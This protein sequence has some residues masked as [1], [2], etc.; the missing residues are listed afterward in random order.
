MYVCMYVCMY[1]SINDTLYL[2]HVD[3]ENGALLSCFLPH[4][5]F[6]KIEART[7]RRPF[8]CLAGAFEYE[9]AILGLEEKHAVGQEYYINFYGKC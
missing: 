6:P 7:P 5:H 9:C 1:V 4:V 8:Q 3:E 2:H